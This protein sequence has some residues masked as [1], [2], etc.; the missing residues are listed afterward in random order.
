MADDDAPPGVPE[1]VVTYGDMMSLLLTFFI[2]LVSLSEVKANKKYRAVL[3]S[4]QHTIGYRSGPMMPPGDDFPLNSLVE[5]LTSL[6]SYSD[7]EQG[8]GGVK[9]PQQVPG[10]DLRV[11][12]PRHGRAVRAGELV[13]FEQFSTEL[14]DEARQRITKIAEVLAGKP[15]K[16]EIR[17]HTGVTPLPN[18][19][20]E[21]ELVRLS[22]QRAR[23]VA[24]QL[25][26]AG[27]ESPRIRVIALGSH[28][29]LP[30][31]ND[32]EALRDDRVEVMVLDTDASDYV[33]A[34]APSR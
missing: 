21:A 13:L 4:L 9:G 18:N 32:A 34:S 11:R 27:I 17:G 24:A 28:E 7:E 33:G 15:N 22:F 25:M 10:Q 6:G 26:A 19:P 31:S 2:M 30:K 1:W 23:T 3:E 29:P 5:R 14:T 16:V 8:S 20:G 12:M